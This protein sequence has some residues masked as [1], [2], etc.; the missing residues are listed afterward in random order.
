MN[1]LHI[2]LPSLR[3]HA[4]GFDRLFEEVSNTFANS[5]TDNYPPYNIV[6]LDET[7]YVIEVA[8][9][10]FAENELEVEL[11]DSVLTVKGQKEKKETEAQ[12]LHRGISARNFER[13]FTLNSD[14]EVRAAT[15]ENGI[16]AIALEHVIPD[17][18]KPR[19]IALTFKK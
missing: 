14:L 12:Y 9:S 17:E 6:R 13:T 4:V 15:V 2:D 7:H 16:L 1:T 8:V 11:K 18:K 5:R 10:G 3:R 19:K